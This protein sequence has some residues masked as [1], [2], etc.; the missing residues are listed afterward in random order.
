MAKKQSRHKGRLSKKQEAKL[1]ALFD[2][3]RQ[4]TTDNESE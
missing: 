1:Y 4:E 2:A 3:K